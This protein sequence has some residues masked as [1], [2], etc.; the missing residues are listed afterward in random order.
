VR[1]TAQGK[2]FRELFYRFNFSI[3]AKNECGAA[4]GFFDQV[5]ETSGE[6]SSLFPKAKIGPTGLE[7]ED[8]A[9][10]RLPGFGGTQ[11]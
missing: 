2:F 9:S 1:F 10:S 6:F 8:R 11:P 5:R 4:F 7:K 3:H